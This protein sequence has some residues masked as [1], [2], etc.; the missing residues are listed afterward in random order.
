MKRNAPLLI[1][2]ILLVSYVALT[3]HQ[4]VSSA[5]ASVISV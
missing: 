4:V 3:A 5:V 2:V 1:I